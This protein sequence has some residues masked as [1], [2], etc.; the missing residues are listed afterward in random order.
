MSGLA[1]AA[2]PFQFTTLYDNTASVGNM[3]IDELHNF[4]LEKS[5]KSS[6]RYRAVCS[7]TI[8]GK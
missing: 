2:I 5:G 7:Q 1:P 3:F 6:R 4:D 8:R